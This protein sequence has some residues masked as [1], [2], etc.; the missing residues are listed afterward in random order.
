MDYN[1][2]NFS[3]D[4]QV[5]WLRF[6]RREKLN[7]LNPDFIVELGHAV[8]ICS[9]NNDIRVVVLTGNPKA[10]IAGADIK[11]MAEAGVDDAYKLSE[12]TNFVQNKISRLAK[13]SIA[14][15]SG[16]ALGAGCEVALCCDFRIGAENAILG[17]PEINLGIIPGGGGTQRLPRLI[18]I[19]PAMRLILTGELVKA[20]E[21]EKIGLLDKVVPLEGFEASVSSFAAQ[22]AKKPPIAVRAAKQAILCGIDSS[23]DNGLILEQNLFAMLF[24]TKDQRIGMRAFLEKQT[25]EFS[26]Q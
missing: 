17:L 9:K 21:A 10:F 16:Y 3:I 18:G 11:N 8:E 5:A 12:L 1:Y 2:L 23:L 13:P 19:G 14:A 20:E 7:A 22:L 26:G 25:P 15:I 6:A 24:G 4:N